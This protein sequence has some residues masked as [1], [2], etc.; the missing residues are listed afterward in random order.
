MAFKQTKVNYNEP[1]KCSLIRF[2]PDAMEA[3][4]VPSPCPYFAKTINVKTLLSD[5]KDI[6]PSN[7][8]LKFSV[9][10]AIGT[11]FLSMCEIKE[12]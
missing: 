12:S 8:M 6:Q 11:S 3:L 10:M 2:T 9:V 4:V 1:Q 7:S 5:K